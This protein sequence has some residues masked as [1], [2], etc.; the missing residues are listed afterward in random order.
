[1]IS[2]N[3]MIFFNTAYMK[4]YQGNWLIDVPHYGGEFIKQNRW[5][6]E[7]FNFKPFQGM[8]YG[9]VEPGLTVISGRQRNINISRLARPGERRINDRITQ[10]LVIWVARPPNSDD[11]VMVGWY[12][13]AS[14]YRTCQRFLQDT[15]RILPNGSFDY[16]T[17]ARESDCHLIPENN[18]IVVIPR[19]TE[20]TL[21]HSNIW[22]ADSVPGDNVKNRVIQYIN[23]WKVSPNI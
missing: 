8:M 1:M 21:G 14:V 18:R 16:F 19:G 7:V 17:S 6:G 11:S 15:S 13:E 20:G 10:I 12:E 2:I 22:Y 23:N 4:N 3:R 9:Y 5:G